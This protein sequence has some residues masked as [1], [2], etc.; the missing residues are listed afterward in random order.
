[1][2]TNPDDYDIEITDDE[3]AYL[4][5]KYLSDQKKLGRNIVPMREVYQYL[6]CDLPDDLENEFMVIRDEIADQLA[7]EDAKRRLLLN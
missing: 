6:E 7:E 4:I 2:I 1:M 3:V 5:M